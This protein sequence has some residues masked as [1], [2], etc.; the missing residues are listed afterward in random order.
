MVVIKKDSFNELVELV[1]QGLTTTTEDKP[2]SEEVSHVDT[3]DVLPKT[4]DLEKEKKKEYVEFV[5]E[6]ASRTGKTIADVFF[7]YLKEL[8]LIKSPYFLSLLFLIILGITTKTLFD[9][10]NLPYF[11][12]VYIILSLFSFIMRKSKKEKKAK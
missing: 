1:A 3:V 5:D 10:K 2:L 4:G 11:A 9:Y 12:G 7:Y 8:K 6:F